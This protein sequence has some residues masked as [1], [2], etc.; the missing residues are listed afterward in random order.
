MKLKILCD[1]V[2][3]HNTTLPVSKV[4]DALKL[5]NMAGGKELEIKAHVP[6]GDRHVRVTFATGMGEKNWNTWNLFSDHVEIEGVEPNNN[7]RDDD[8]PKAATAGR[9]IRLPGGLTANLEGSIIK[10]GDFT[11]AEAT[12]QGTRIPANR[13][14]VSNIIKVAHIMQE[15][16]ERVGDRPISVNSWY[17][18]PVS[19][20]RVGG[21]SRSRHII[22][23][24]IDFT[25]QGLKPG[26]VYK[27]LDGWW[28]GRGGLASS[29]TFT[30]IDGRGYRARWTY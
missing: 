22:G 17:R 6:V 3:K 8:E 14:V 20:R 5:L 25:V 10:G 15:V 11:W 30:H 26:E 9:I 23:D 18:D 7:P 1:T 16:R 12:K 21:A 19:N 13:A 28:G 24:A 4:Q 29:N 27:M 2:A